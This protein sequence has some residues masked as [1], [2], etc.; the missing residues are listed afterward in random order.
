MNKY[1]SDQ[2]TLT[3]CP[4]GKLDTLM[5]RQLEKELADAFDPSYRELIID[6]REVDYISSAFLRL[7]LTYIKQLG[8]EHFYLTHVSPVV[9]MVLKVANLTELCRD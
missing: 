1:F 8:N 2:K 5:T 6:L 3:C 7:C 4:A 9:L